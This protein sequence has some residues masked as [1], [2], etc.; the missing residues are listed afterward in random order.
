M[1][2]PQRC[3]IRANICPDIFPGKKFTAEVNL[4]L[5]GVSSSSDLQNPKFYLIKERD[6]DVDEFERLFAK[7]IR[8]IFSESS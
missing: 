4:K 6:R 8:Q 5:K 1:G 7:K 2:I 3:R